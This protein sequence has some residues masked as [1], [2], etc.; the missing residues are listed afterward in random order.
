MGN[1]IPGT[2]IFG[3]DSYLKAYYSRKNDKYCSGLLNNM[4]L[5][6]RIVELGVN[7]LLK[8]MDCVLDDMLEANVAMILL[9]PE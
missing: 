4:F 9:F 3:S 6:M 8:I 2:F 7:T 5:P 1:C